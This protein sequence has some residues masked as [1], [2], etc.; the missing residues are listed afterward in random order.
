[1]KRRPKKA[2]HPAL[3][4][5]PSGIQG[6][7][8][9]TGGGLPSG[10]P[11]LL[12]GGAGCG[13]TL[14]AMEF[15]MRGATQYGEPGVFMAFEETAPELAQNVRSLGFDLD[16][17]IRRKKVFVDFVRIERAEIQETGD[18][19]LE[20]LFV[21]L[22]HAIKTIGARRVVLD[23]IEA[24]FGGFSNEAVLRAELRRLFHW[25][26]DKGVT[27]VITGERGERTLTRQGLEEY[28]SDCVIFLDHRVVNQ[29]STRRLRIVKYRGTVHGTNEYPFLI[30]E[31]GITVLPITSLELQ[32]RASTER[33][34]SGIARLDTMLGG[35][36]YFR[37]STVLITGSSGTGKTSMAAH[38]ADA[39]C[40][41]GER[42]LY[43]CFEESE[44][45]ML[46]N[47]RSIGLR[48]QPWVDKG[49]LRF[50]TTRSTHYGLEMHLATFQKLFQEFSPRAVVIDPIDSLIQ[51]GTLADAS[52][53]ILRFI[54]F[55]KTQGVTALLTNLTTGGTAAEASG[56]NISSMS[57]TWLLLRDMETGGERNRVIYVLKSRGM[58]HSNQLREFRITDGG[59]K[60]L[61]AY[62]GPG[63]VLTGSMRLSQEARD[64]AEALIRDQEISAKGRQLA[65]RREA[66]EARIAAMRKEFEADEREGA[67][68]IGEDRVRAR[69]V[70]QNRDDL[71]VSRQ[72]DKAVRHNNQ[73]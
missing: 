8:E 40:R 41:R 13:K 57:D 43:I 29:V 50:C 27:A 48:L 65:A 37:G 68:I 30:D 44:P 26:K 63:G 22:D 31:S 10:R 3:R 2:G 51:A 4:K 12:C 7:D 56:L 59:V 5:T 47:M 73:E 9:I 61:D 24:L 32:H 64:R 1:M 34:S 70:K 53:M 36:G 54:D 71:A 38:F 42:C 35:K 19:D 72:A 39:T 55:L 16:E 67:R 21:R 17:L 46:R 45:Q 6:L 15:L 69:V 62:T 28:V 66:L 52:M 20:G 23:T 11:T 60:L 58:A 33:V 18:Y 49:L 14:L 25:L